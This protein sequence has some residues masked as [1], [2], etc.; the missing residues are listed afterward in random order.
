MRCFFSQLFKFCYC[1]CFILPRG[2]TFFQRY[3]RFLAPLTILP[4]I[5]SL[6]EE[7][8]SDVKTESN[9]SH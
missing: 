1:D 6:F 5:Q 2:A 8:L 9:S 3:L 7:T 4:K